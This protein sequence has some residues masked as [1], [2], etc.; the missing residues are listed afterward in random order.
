MT[1]L[2]KETCLDAIAHRRPP[3]ILIIE[4]ALIFKEFKETDILTRWVL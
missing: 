1:R 2:K 4:N 3:K